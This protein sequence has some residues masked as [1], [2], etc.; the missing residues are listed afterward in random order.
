MPPGL[1][2]QPSNQQQQTN[3][4]QQ[5]QQA[6]QL[7]QQLGPIGTSLLGQQSSLMS[8]PP[9]GVLNLGSN[10]NAAAG[11]ASSLGMLGASAFQSAP[12]SSSSLSSLI[13]DPSTVSLN[14]LSSQLS[15]SLI[16]S[17]D[18][19]QLQ[20]YLIMQLQ[21]QQSLQQLQQQQQ[22]LQ[23]QQQVQQQVQQQQ[24]QQQQIQQQQQQQINP[25]QSSAL[26][27]ASSTALQFMPPPRP[28][29][30]T[31]G[32]AIKLR[33]NHFT[34]QI[35]KGFIYHYTVTILPDKCPK[36]INRDI[37]NT[38][39]QAKP[40]LFANQK[41]V[42]DGKKN[43]YTKEYLNNIGAEKVDVEVTLP[44]EGKD[45]LFKVTI[46]FEAKVSLYALEDALQGKNMTVPYDSI[47]ALDVIMRHLP[48]MRYTPVGRSF[49]SPPQVDFNNPLGGGREVWFGFHQSV[50]PS[51]W[52][53]SLNIDVSATA[54]YKSQPVIDFLCEI[55]DIQTIQ[56][57]NKPL[58]DAQ[59]VKFTKEIKGLKIEITHCG[60]MRRKY[61]VCNVTRRPAHTQTFPLQL[62]TGQ[63][64]ECTVAKYFLD[65]H[66][67]KLQLV[68]YLNNL[69]FSPLLEV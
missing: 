12:P 50:R 68:F 65:K 51:Q 11:F 48:S 39:V 49:F 15:Q 54:F 24:Q 29:I 61:R 59:R 63:S 53:M 40:H 4:Q 25:I 33:A 9:P 35:P 43:L 57:H 22:L 21:Q 66:H 36:R 17:D 45:R 20:Q 41:P 42:F 1:P 32:K 62:E 64:L 44:G 47:Q 37:L 26:A 14:T 18:N 23:Q 3:Q 31:E 46:R 38:L 34:I 16:L 10:P 7:T 67:I 2:Q 27:P 8:G 58:N 5:Q 19:L 56:E 28:S 30:G 60:P 13:L 52:K 55:L 69:S 6:S